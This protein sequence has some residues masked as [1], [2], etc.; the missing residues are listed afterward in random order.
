MCLIA[1]YA[2]LYGGGEVTIRGNEN[3]SWPQLKRENATLS[4]NAREHHVHR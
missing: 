3:N 2:D 4:Y 1:S